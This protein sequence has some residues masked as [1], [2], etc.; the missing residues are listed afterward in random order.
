MDKPTIDSNLN[1]RRAIGAA[2]PLA[3]RNDQEVLKVTYIGFDRA[4]HIG[5]IVISKALAQDVV[6][7]FELAEQLRF[8]IEKVVPAPVYDGDD[9]RL[10]ALNVSSGFNYRKIAGAKKLSLHA[11][12]QAF[13]INPHQNPYIRREGALVIAPP[14]ANWNQ[15]MPGTLHHDHQLVQF[16]LE[17]GWEWGGDWSLENSGRI[18]YQHF[19]KDLTIDQQG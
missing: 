5:Q 13:D 14:N 12:G 3:I 19:Q 1:G 7:W 9:N 17:R 6:D 16:M 10:M 15:D 8:P 11:T 2:G 18:D 4:K